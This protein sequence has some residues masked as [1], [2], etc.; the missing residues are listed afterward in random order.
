MI[1]SPPKM[2]TL[3]RASLL[4]AP[5]SPEP[6]LPRHGKMHRQSCICVE[7]SLLCFRFRFEGYFAFVLDLFVLVGEFKFGGQIVELFLFL[8]HSNIESVGVQRRS[9]GIPMLVFRRRTVFVLSS[10]SKRISRWC[11]RLNLLILSW[12][13]RRT[14]TSSA[15][16]SSAFES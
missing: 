16:S 4:P 14:S 7:V 8:L 15:A 5:A 3:P 6:A 10:S 2:L 9:G 13:S 12:S 1:A 11:R